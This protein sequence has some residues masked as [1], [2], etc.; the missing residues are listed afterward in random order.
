MPSTL[1]QYFFVLICLIYLQMENLKN[2]RKPV[3]FS[4]FQFIKN[5]ENVKGFYDNKLQ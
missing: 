1:P 5:N 3:A 2:D 4:F